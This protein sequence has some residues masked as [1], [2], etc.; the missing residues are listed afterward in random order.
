MTIAVD[1]N[2]TIAVADGKMKEERTFTDS[3][4]SKL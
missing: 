1:E 2:M 3:Q 4:R